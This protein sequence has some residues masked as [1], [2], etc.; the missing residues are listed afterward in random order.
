MTALSPDK[1]KTIRLLAFDYDGV[2][3]DGTIIDSDGKMLRQGHAKDG[4][5]IQWATRTQSPSYR[6]Q[7]TQR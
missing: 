1:L 6:R 3:T 7:R 5:A 2:F 4:F